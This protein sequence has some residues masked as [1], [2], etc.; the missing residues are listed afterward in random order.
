V[1]S[2]TSALH[3]G[4]WRHVVGTLW[5][6]YDTAA[7]DVADRV[8]PALVSGGRLDASGAAAALH[9]TVRELRDGHRDRPAAWAPFIHFGP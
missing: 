2:L 6:V 8:Y 4:G 5:S 3:Y 1:I 9:H 7:A